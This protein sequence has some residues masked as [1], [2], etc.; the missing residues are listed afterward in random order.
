MKYGKL[1]YI[2]HPLPIHDTMIEDNSF[3][4]LS[5]GEKLIERKE[6]KRKTENI[7]N[8]T[9]KDM[10][11]TL[12]WSVKNGEFDVFIGVDNLNAL[13]GIILKKLR[14]VKKVVYYTIDYFPTR[15]NN[16]LLNKLYHA[17]ENFCVMHADEVWNVS[18]VMVYAREKQNG[19]NKT[20]RKKQYTIPIGV[21][22]EKSPRKKFLQIGKTKLIFSGHLVPHMGVDLAIRSMPSILNHIPDATL[23]IIGGGQEENKLRRMVTQLKLEKHVVFWGWI[24]DRKKLEE[25]LSTGAVG[26]APFNTEILDEKVK[27]ADPGKIKDYM[28][29]GMPVIVTDAISTADKIKKSKSGIVIQYKSE[30]FVDAVVTLLKDNNILKEYRENALSYVRQFDYQLLFRKHVERVLNC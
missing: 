19:I 22:F 9:V 8:S 17:I 24:R 7:F 10:I 26:I 23:E 25:I 21:W 14:K 28:V 12:Y 27:N 1:L 15:F 13:S 29:M 6:Q 5:E 4:E 2:S 18:P 16:Q 3:Y 30:D 20:L 11:F